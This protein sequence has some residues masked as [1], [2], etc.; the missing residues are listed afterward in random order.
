MLLWHKSPFL[1]IQLL[2]INL[3]TDSFPAIALGMEPVEDTI[4][5]HPP[6]PKKEGLFAH[7]FG[8]QI[9]LQG[10]LFGILALLAFYIGEKTT[11]ELASGQTLAFMVLSLSQIIQ[12]FNMRSSRSLF[13]IGVFSNH[14]LNWAALVSVL[15]VCLILFTPLSTIFGLVQLSIPHYIIGLSF[16]ILPILI[17]ELTKAVFP[18][19]L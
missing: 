1:S 15:L 16:I 5:E 6:K 4:M 12:S 9:I 8:I 3:V 2:W 10:F 7:G 13:T 11:G 19:K 14:K 17:M 18:E